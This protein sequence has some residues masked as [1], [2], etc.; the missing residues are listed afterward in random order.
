MM[1]RINRQ[2]LFHHDLFAA[3]RLT[4]HVCTKRLPASRL[5]PPT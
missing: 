2:A 5:A 3:G 1:H 4:M